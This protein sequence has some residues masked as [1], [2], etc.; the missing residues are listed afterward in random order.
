MSRR[1]RAALRLCWVAV[2][3]LVVYVA[4]HIVEHVRTS[5]ALA[6]LLHAT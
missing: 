1:E 4:P 3:V 6:P 5:A 2:L